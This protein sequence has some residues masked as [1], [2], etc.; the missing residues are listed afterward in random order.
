MKKEDDKVEA[1]FRKREKDP[2][3]I[4]YMKLLV[5]RSKDHSLS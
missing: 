4:E 2:R 5:E 1:E 3:F